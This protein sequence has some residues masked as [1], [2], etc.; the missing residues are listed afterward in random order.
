MILWYLVGFRFLADIESFVLCGTK[1]WNL[2]GRARVGYFSDPVIP[3]VLAYLCEAFKPSD[4]G[5][6]RKQVDVA[7][8]S[9]R[10][11]HVEGRQGKWRAERVMGV[12]D[13]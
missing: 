13:Y 7:T 8:W 11:R 6:W 5:T 3:F 4:F 12:V 10:L 9:S 1:V 2:Y